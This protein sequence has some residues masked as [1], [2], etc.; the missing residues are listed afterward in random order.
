MQH[1]RSL[2]TGFLVVGSGLDYWG[3]YYE[4]R[5]LFTV[6]RED[7]LWTFGKQRMAVDEFGD[8]H[9]DWPEYPKRLTGKEVI[10]LLK[11]PTPTSEE[12]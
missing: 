1:H 12:E 5:D 10:R 3:E 11:L 2:M 4:G 6:A 9:I 8:E 7:M